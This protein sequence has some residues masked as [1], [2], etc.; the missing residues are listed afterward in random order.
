MKREE[1]NSKMDFIMQL[2]TIWFNTTP[3]IRTT[4]KM[5]VYWLHSTYEL[6]NSYLMASTDARFKGIRHITYTEEL[7]VELLCPSCPE[8]NLVNFTFIILQARYPNYKY[9]RVL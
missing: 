2:L 3:H 9:N 6:F 8:K 5:Q 4:Y 7:R 1:N